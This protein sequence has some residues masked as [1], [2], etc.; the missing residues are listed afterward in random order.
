[1]KVDKQSILEWVDREI[2]NATKERNNAYT[3]ETRIY[4]NGKVS[5]LQDL[6]YELGR[7]N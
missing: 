7:D 4:Y 2:D 5:I 1:M 6:R 3:S